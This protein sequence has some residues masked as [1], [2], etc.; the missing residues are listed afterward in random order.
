MNQPK[1]LINCAVL[2]ARWAE[3]VSHHLA[4]ALAVDIFQLR[5]LVKIAVRASFRGYEPDSSKSER[6]IR[7]G[8]RNMLVT[9]FITSM[10]LSAMSAVCGNLI[11]YNTLII[12]YGMMM[13]AFAVL[14]EYNDLILNADDAEILFSKPI[15]S[16]TIYWA[17]LITLTIFVLLYSA[18]LLLMPSMASF[19]FAKSKFY[20]MPFSFLIMM[21]GC[22]VSA[23]LVVHL[24]VQ[25]L[26]RFD[27][28]R[29]TGLLTYFQAG[30]SL[31]LFYGYYKLL[32]YK[33]AAGSVSIARAVENVQAAASSGSN[34]FNLILDQSVVFYFLPPSWFAGSIDLLLGDTTLRTLNLSMTALCVIVG[35][36]LLM[37]KVA[38]ASYLHHLA[39]HALDSQSQPGLRDAGEVTHSRTDDQQWRLRGILSRFK[40]ALRSTVGSSFP[41]LTRAGYHLVSRY[42]K[43][44]GRLRRG[45]YPFFGIILFYFL[46]GIENKNFLIDIFQ[47]HSGTDVLGAHSVYVLLPLCVLIATNATKYCS[48][49]RAAWIFYA[50]PVELR[51]F[52]LGYRLA[53]LGR[54]YGPIWL[55]LLLLYFFKMSLG[56]LL[57]QMLA[58]FLIILFLLSLSFLFDPHLALSQAPRLHAGFLKFT[59]ILA[60]LVAIAQG[61]LILE[62]IS[63]KHEISIGVFYLALM[64]VTALWSL[65]EFSQLKRLEPVIV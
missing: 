43:R 23:F 60:L 16:Q 64:I 18:S 48:D 24:Y 54:I 52:H 11:T 65:F 7:S 58:L 49:W 59:L 12:S 29:L 9:Y 19:R 1:S 57:L 20:L 36:G 28:N 56:P 2:V 38:P 61:I 4:F 47:A 26:K 25:L 45:I 40:S 35:V 41:P 10:G 32:L 34:P 42:L 6:S 44:D 39:A 5:V 31:V 13:T 63:S 55:L 8:F 22:L 17:R 3:V 50:A 14:I 15:T 46:Y 30:F 51:Q 21:I 37:F 27:P 53:T 33:Q 62:Y